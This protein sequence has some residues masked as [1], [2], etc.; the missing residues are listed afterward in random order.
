MA[1]PEDSQKNKSLPPPP[2]LIPLPNNHAMV[3]QAHTLA[4]GCH[5]GDVA[6]LANLEDYFSPV[7]TLTCSQIIRILC[8]A[9]HFIDILLQKI[10]VA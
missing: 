7:Q 5:I 9:H 6:R 10:E 4:P 2:P 3:E 8:L 1:I